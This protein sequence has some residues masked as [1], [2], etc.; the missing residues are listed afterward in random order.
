MAELD[1]DE[2]AEV[3]A[4]SIGFVFQ[5]STC[6]RAYRLSKTSCCRWPCTNVPHGQR[7]MRAVH[8]LQAVRCPSTAGTR[9]PSS[10]GGQA[11]VTVARALVNDR[12][13]SWPMSRR[14]P[15][16]PTGPCD[17]DLP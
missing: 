6:C 4:L 9:L 10:P 7:E 11:R 5:A 14:K 2:L 15:G 12:P 1:D 13:S 8:A 16:L 3:R 17:G